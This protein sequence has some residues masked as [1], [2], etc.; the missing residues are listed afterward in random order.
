[1]IGVD[2]SDDVRHNHPS[3]NWNM[4]S[5]LIKR[6]LIFACMSLGLATSLFAQD[7]TITIKSDDKPKVEVKED[8]KPPFTGTRPAVDVAILLDTSNSMDGLISQAKS[9]LWTIVQQFANAE[10]AGK[11]PQL[12]VSVF[13]YGNTKLPASENYIRQ[14][15]QLTDDLDKVS[16]A[17]FSLKTNCLLYTSPSPR[18]S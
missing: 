3:A 4:M 8:G 10:K 12:R 15:V 14:V 18:D 6:F 13:E 5:Y 16:E 7:V 11:T 9:Q 2:P 17:L 1:M